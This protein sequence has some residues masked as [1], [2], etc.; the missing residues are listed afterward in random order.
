MEGR[1]R[2]KYGWSIY[3]TLAVTRWVQRA[4]LRVRSGPRAVRIMK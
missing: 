1:A 3:G 2:D 4:L